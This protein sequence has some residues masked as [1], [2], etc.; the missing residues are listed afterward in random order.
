M[1]T[2]LMFPGQGSQYYG[3]GI[4][5]LDKY[6][7]LEEFIFKADKILNENFTKIFN[8]EKSYKNTYHTQMMIVITQSMILEILRQ[9]NITYDGVIGFSLGDMTAAY[10]SGLYDYETLI[11]LTAVRA[12]SMQKACYESEGTMAAVLKLEKEVVEKICQDINKKS[13]YMVPVNYNAPLQ[14]VIS[15]HK[16]SL[17]K[18]LTV[19]KEKG[20]RLI[21]LNVDGAFHTELMKVDLDEYKNKLNDINFFDPKFEKFSNVSGDVI[22]V[23]FHKDMYEQVFSPVYT[24]KMFENALLRGY[25]KFIEVGPGGILSGLLNKLSHNAKIIT[26]KS[27]SL[28]EEIL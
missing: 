21:P 13:D 10:A 26:I 2:I 20:G 18:F 22:K 12:K 3:M 11:R 16:S 8:D 17:E 6:P 9:K 24:Q 4:E 14:T 25:N 1:K 27:A 23:N 7:N 5:L 19:V 15:G 28:L